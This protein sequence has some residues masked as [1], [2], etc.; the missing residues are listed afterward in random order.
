MGHVTAQVLTLL[1][2]LVFYHKIPLPVR[3]GRRYLAKNWKLDAKL[4]AIGLPA[5]L[6]LVLP[7]LLVSALNAIFAAYSEIYVV[8]LGI[9]YKLQTFLYLPANGV[10]QGM[11]PLI[12]YNYGAGEQQ[13]VRRIYGLALAINGCI[14]AL[15]T[16][17]LLVGARPFNGVVYRSSPYCGGRRYGAAYYQRRFFGFG[18]IYYHLRRFGGLGY[19]RAFLSYLLMPLCGGYSAGGLGA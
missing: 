11:R 2:Y 16:L 9:Y 6:N 7:S 10:I 18:G 8:I 14:M 1:L 4:Y 5:T 12:G 15:G 13:R 19:G 17:V 3:L